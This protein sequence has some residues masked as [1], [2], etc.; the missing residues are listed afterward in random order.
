MFFYNTQH[1]ILFLATASSFSLQAMSLKD[2]G[3]MQAFK[4]KQEIT[5]PSSSFEDLSQ[6]LDKNVWYTQP[7]TTYSMQQQSQISQGILEKKVDKTQKTTEHR[8]EPIKPIRVEEGWMCPLCEKIFKWNSGVYAHMRG[9]CKQRSQMNVYICPFFDSLTGQK[10]DHIANS[11]NALYYHKKYYCDFRPDKQLYV[12][13][14]AALGCPKKP[15]KALP[16]CKSHEKTC[17]YKNMR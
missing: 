15:Y 2:I 3:N 11:Y 14:F 10:C 8:L 16:D 13:A 6:Q 4:K 7:E 12:C 17:P 9:N 1:I 5:V